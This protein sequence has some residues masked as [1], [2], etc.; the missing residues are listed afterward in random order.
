MKKQAAKKAGAKKSASKK[1]TKSQADE[2]SL[3][4]EFFIDGIKDIYWAEKQL[5]KSLPKM[6]KACTTDELRDA[7]NEHLEVTEEQVA[8]LEKVF[9]LL[10]EKAQGKKCEAM[11]G[12]VKEANEIV[13]ETEKGSVTRDAAIICAAQKVEHYEIASYGSLAQLARTLGESE[14]A[15]LLAQTLEEEKETDENL[16]QL[17]ES[18]INEEA[19]EEGA[20]PAEE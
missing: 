17:A 9:E 10:D 5:T 8:R 16:T 3:L 2:K 13:D 1:A 6:A 14:V 20:V 12:L 15:D 7:I 11:A 18:Q 4:R 19:L